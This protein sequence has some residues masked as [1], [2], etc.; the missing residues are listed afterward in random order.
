MAL[1]FPNSTYEAEFVKAMPQYE[2][3]ASAGEASLFKSRGF[4]DTLVTDI[5]KLNEVYNCLNRIVLN[6]IDVA[7]VKDP[8][9]LGDFGASYVNEY[10]AGVQRM[11]IY[12]VKGTS[13][14]FKNIPKQGVNMQQFRPGKVEQRFFEIN[15]DYANYLSIQEFQIRQMFVNEFGIS[16]FY[17]GMLSQLKND[18]KLNKYMAV[19]EALNAAINNT[20]HPLQDTQKITLASW[21]ADPTS[22]ELNDF[23]L[24]IKNIVSH[25]EATPATS[26]Y[27]ALGFKTAQNVSRMRLLCRV[28]I[29]NLIQTRLQK[30]FVGADNLTLPF[31]I[32][33]VEDFGGLVP[34]AEST[35]ETQ[36]YP[37]YDVESGEQIGFAQTE[38]ATVAQYTED[39]VYLK[40]PN[41]NVLAVLADKEVIF[42]VQHNPF[43]IMAA[44]YNVAGLYITQ[45]ATC[46]DNMIKYDA[47]YNFITISKPST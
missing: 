23:I 47:L 5:T 29:K 37:V 8:F 4:L 33:E 18:Y 21:S 40:D 13:P 14:L 27:N 15:F 6:K 36:L 12:P 1:G 20:D 28:G 34:Y 38:G 25:M 9:R 26:A 10:A 41:E 44:P 2:G 45:H 17:A 46:P 32:I 3:Y 42:H 7:D 19:K 11:A 22:D 43:R 30:L 16:D 35:F 24:Q 31:N 39:E